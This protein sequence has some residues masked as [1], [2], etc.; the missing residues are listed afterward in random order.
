MSWQSVSVIPVL[1]AAMW[2]APQ[3]GTGDRA[4]DFKLK[5]LRGEDVTLGQFYGKVV[6]LDFWAT[7]CAPCKEALP[8]YVRLVD[9]Y[10][11]EGFVVLA[12][13]I[14]NELA[15]TARFL[16]DKKLEIVPLW[17]GRKK[18]VSAYKVEKMPTSYLIDRQGI[19]R[20]VNEGYEDDDLS[21]L[22]DHIRSLLR[23]RQ[24][25]ALAGN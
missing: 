18:V 14:D 12:V 16:R 24:T 21:E 22:E 25:A 5:N 19:I 13:N 15:N 17:D 3:A 6:L 11:S 4:I 10:G 2:G 9:R 7:W 23:A 8:E 20:Y 1:I